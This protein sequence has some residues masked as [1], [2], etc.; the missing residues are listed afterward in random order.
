V[1]G[2]SPEVHDGPTAGGGSD[3]LGATGQG[4]GRAHDDTV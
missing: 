2:W 1:E 4:P 3:G